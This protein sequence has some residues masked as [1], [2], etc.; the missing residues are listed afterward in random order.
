M[1]STEEAAVDHAIRFGP[2]DI[3]YDARVLTPRPW[4]ELQSW[5]AAELARDA[6][7]GR[8]LELCAGAGH[9]GL[10]AALAAERDL[11]AVDLNPAA[12]AF[13]TRN[14]QDAGLA[15]RVE[16]RNAALETACG[17]GEVF[18]VI[19][20]DPPWVRAAETSRYPEDPLSAIDG[21]V[22]GLDVARSCL[23]VIEAHLAGGGS[24]LLQLGTREQVGV[25]RA[26]LPG[27]LVIGEVRGET[28]GVV[29]LVHRANAPRELT[30]G[31]F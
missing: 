28:R 19:I 5:W 20:A 13:A 23:R 17:L 1:T 18:P 9:I 30:A 6:P 2:L 25:L 21:G 3:A 31:T 14:A 12:C 16:V 29:A 24:A 15:D 7:E 27:A 10:L 11:V 26:E 4:T 22:D 8:I